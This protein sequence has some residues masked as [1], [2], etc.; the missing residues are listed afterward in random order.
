MPP[1]VPRPSIEI[2]GLAVHLAGKAVLSDISLS[3]H[4]QIVALVGPNGA[5]KSTLLRVLATLLVPTRGRVTVGGS[6]LTTRRGAAAAR[7]RLG[8]LPQ[9]T[10]FPPEFRVREAVEYAAWL[11]RVPSKRRRDAVDQTISDLDLGG[12]EG[13][14]LRSL[15]GG[16]KRRVY[17]GQ[18]LVHEPELLLLDEPTTGVDAGHRVDVRRLVRKL[19]TQRL[20]VLSTH[21]IEDIEVLADRVIA[22]RDG[23]VSYDGTPAELADM[24]GER[25][26][27]HDARAVERGLR[28]V[29]GLL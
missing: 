9:E 23:R 12:V 11:K 16:T 29:A 7:E 18:A 2:E 6:A 25:E 19:A 27:S 15:S 14:Q 21:L 1:D 24:G 17:I 13:A 22:I 28:A 10:T 8:Y 20:V 26:T 3:L 5:G 4:P